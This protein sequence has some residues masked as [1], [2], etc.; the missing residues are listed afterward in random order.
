MPRPYVTCGLCAYAGI[1]DGS[2]LTKRICRLGPGQIIQMGPQ[3][4][5]TIQP[6]KGSQDGC[7]Q[8]D[9]RET[10]SPIIGA[11]P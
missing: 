10:S 8:G 1:G 3:Q 5:M 11:R 2:D 7:F 9:V 4:F 6:V